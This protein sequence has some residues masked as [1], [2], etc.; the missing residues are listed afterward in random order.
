M[1]AKFSRPKSSDDKHGSKLQCAPKQSPEIIE[2]TYNMP[3]GEKAT[4]R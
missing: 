1:E 3:G 4:K 2:S